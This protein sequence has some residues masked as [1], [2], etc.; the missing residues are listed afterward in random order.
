MD[1]KETADYD[2][3]LR[4][5]NKDQ[6]NPLAD[7]LGLTDEDR[8]NIDTEKEWKKHWKGMPEFEQDDNEPFRTIYVHFRNEADYKEFAA[9]IKQSLTD[10]TKSIWHP[11]LDITKNS[12]LRWIENE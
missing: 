9:I 8:N 6:S 4:Q 1:V 12:L 5:T 11:R 7:A 3:L 2:N 10:K